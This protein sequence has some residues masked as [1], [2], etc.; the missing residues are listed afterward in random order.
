MAW[1]ALHWT[2][3]LFHLGLDLSGGF[4]LRCAMGMCAH[5]HHQY[6]VWIIGAI[7]ISISTVILIG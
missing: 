2:D 3:I 1:L 7:I 5:K 4:T 6:I